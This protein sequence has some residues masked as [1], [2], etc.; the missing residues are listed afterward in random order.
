MLSWLLTSDDAWAPGSGVGVAESGCGAG[1]RRE[2][3]RPPRVGVF[4]MGW[5]GVGGGLLA[6]LAGV[7]GGLL[8]FLK[9]DFYPCAIIKDRGVPGKIQRS[10]APLL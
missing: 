2:Q 10:S 4:K 6:F 1:R 3:P 9:R 7:G 5:A 8:A